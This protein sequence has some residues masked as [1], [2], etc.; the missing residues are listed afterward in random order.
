MRVYIDQNDS[1]KVEVAFMTYN[2]YINILSQLFQDQN[3]EF[4]ESKWDKCVE[5]NIAL[6]RIKD[7]ISQKYKPSDEYINYSFDFNSHAIDY[8][9]AD[10]TE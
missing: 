3:N 5:L 7:K 8:F 6:E 1:D 2:A 10:G 9:K 4:L